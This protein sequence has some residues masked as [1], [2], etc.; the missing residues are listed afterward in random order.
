MNLLFHTPRQNFHNLP[1]LL[2]IFL[3][4]WFLEFR[5]IMGKSSWH[6]SETQ[7]VFVS[8]IFFCFS[9]KF[10]FKIWDIIILIEKYG[11]TIAKKI[12][13]MVAVVFVYGRESH[14]GQK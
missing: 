5:G 10:F 13:Q 1:E 2:A 14:G 7:L 11:C 9:R 4:C 12:Y 6:C 3:N 8:N